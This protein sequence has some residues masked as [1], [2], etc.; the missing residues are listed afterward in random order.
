LIVK[1]GCPLPRK[2]Q[3]SHQGVIMIDLLRR[4]TRCTPRC[5][6]LS[7]IDS[8]TRKHKQILS[9]CCVLCDTSDA[10]K[11]IVAKSTFWD[12]IAYIQPRCCK[13]KR[14]LPMR[15]GEKVRMTEGPFPGLYG[16]IV[17]S[18]R[19][20]VVLAIVVG[21]HTLRVELDRA[22]I[23]PATRRR[24]S[25]LFPNQNLKLSRRAAR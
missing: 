5:E 20:R 11:I 8:P 13:P 25:A 19:R 7:E 14:R 16:T 12:T 9:S 1:R 3:T 2:L 23:V 17:R 4:V 6:A 22:W 10:Q 24:R 15:L 21:S 18:V